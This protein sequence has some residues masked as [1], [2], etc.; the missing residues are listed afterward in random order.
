[1]NVTVSRLVFRYEFEMLNKDVDWHR[2]SEMHLLW[3]KPE[4]LVK[5]TERRV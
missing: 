1:M 5:F 2:D 4:I 3:K